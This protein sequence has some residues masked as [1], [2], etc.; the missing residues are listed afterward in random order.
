MDDLDTLMQNVVP[1]AEK[2]L[3][4]HGTFP[5]YGGAMTTDGEIHLVGVKT[6]VEYDSADALLESLLDSLK[7]GAESGTF[8]A[9]ALVLDVEVTL[10]GAERPTDAIRAVLEHQDGT[11]VEA[12]LPYSR[13]G[14]E[15]TVEY[16]KLIAAQ[17]TKRIW[18]E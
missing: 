10:P 15:G 17:G 13:K 14:E 9:T 12:Y 7:R 6:D 2:L 18:N 1:L 4:E 16:G 11:T 3:E 8:T 5:P